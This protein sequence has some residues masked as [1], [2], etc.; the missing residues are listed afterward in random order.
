MN[1]YS[2]ARLTPAAEPFLSTG[3]SRASSCIFSN[4]RKFPCELRLFTIDA[5]R[6]LSYEPLT[7]YFGGPA[8]NGCTRSS[9]G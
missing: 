1:Q 6:K 2:A 5:A 9:A 3:R 7:A 8:A 4:N